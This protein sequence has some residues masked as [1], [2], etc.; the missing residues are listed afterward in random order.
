MGLIVV[1]VKDI[2]A[3]KVVR[4]GGKGIS[5]RTVILGS[6]GHLTV[7]GIRVSSRGGRDLVI[8]LRKEMLGICQ[9][10]ICVIS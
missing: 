8:N 9:K 6:S 2:R 4:I 3:I 5:K 10:R 7:T 1:V